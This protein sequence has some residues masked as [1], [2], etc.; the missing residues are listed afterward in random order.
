MRSS[1]FY[2]LITA[3]ITIS[4]VAS[5]TKKN[6]SPPP[7]LNPQLFNA[8]PKKN[9][10]GINAFT[11]KHP[12]HHSSNSSTSS[13]SSSTKLEKPK[14]NKLTA[15]LNKNHSTSSNIISSSHN[16]PRPNKTTPNKTTSLVKQR[17]PSWR[18]RGKQATASLRSLRS[19]LDVNNADGNNEGKYSSEESVHCVMEAL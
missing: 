6:S 2:F 13:N 9:T 15:F 19:Q 11:K 5:S 8:R 17:R 7:S 4:T 12:N 10:N 3:S 18:L 14:N 1:I 16:S